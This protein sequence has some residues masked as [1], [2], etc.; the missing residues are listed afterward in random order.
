M[1]I[2]IVWLPQSKFIHLA[3][4]KKMTKY[5]FYS[6]RDQNQEAI[7]SVRAFSRMQAAKY[8]ANRKQMDLKTFLSIFAV[9]K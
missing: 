2:K 7:D 6:R 3:K 5:Y 9:S 4:R 1:N 8:F